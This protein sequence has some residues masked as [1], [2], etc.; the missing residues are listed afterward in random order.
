MEGEKEI[1]HNKFGIWSNDGKS[2]MALQFFRV[3]KYHDFC[4]NILGF[5][6][7]SIKCS[8]RNSEIIYLSIIINKLNISR[9]LQ[10][11]H[12]DWR[13]GTAPTNLDIDS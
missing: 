12:E 7:I 6:Q 1:L 9:I 2:F 5:I 8:T 4:K 13:S 3:F 11:Y 10:S